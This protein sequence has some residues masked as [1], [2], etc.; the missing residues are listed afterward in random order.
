MPENTGGER[1]AHRPASQSL[2]QVFDAGAA[3]LAA[4]MKSTAL[5]G[6]CRIV[7]HLGEGGMAT[8]YLAEDLKHDRHVAVRVLKPGLAAVL[9]AERFVQEMRHW[10]APPCS[11]W[12]QQRAHRSPRWLSTRAV[13]RVPSGV[14][15]N[16]A[17]SRAGAMSW[18][19]ARVSSHAQQ[20]QSVI[21]QHGQL[22]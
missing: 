7:R 22:E 2:D 5:D 9:G 16:A 18:C 8:V 13:A 19:D 12:P 14:R 4:E 3:P 20:P 11:N 21:D 6:R 15:L 1:E 17:P 10:A